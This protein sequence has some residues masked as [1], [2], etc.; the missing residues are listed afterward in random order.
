MKVK[1]RT[2]KSLKMMI[3][4]FVVYL[5]VV[6]TMAERNVIKEIG[7]DKTD[8]KCHLIISIFYMYIRIYRIR[9]EKKGFLTKKH[10]FFVFLNL[11]KK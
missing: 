10:F 5:S 3:Q 11:R 8:S 4:L 6:S 7:K 1:I 2:E 9:V